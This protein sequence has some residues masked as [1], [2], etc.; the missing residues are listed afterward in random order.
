MTC[1]FD[2]FGP[3]TFLKVNFQKPQTSLKAHFSYHMVAQARIELATPGFSV[4]CSTN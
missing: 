4:L 2:L 1:S 3:Q